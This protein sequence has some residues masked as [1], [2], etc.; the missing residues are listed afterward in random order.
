MSDAEKF[1]NQIKRNSAPKPWLIETVLGWLRFAQLKPVEAENHFRKAW[2]LDRNS[3]APATF[4]TDFLMKLEKFDDAH[5][6]RASRRF[7]KLD[8]E[9]ITMRGEAWLKFITQ[10]DQP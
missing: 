9:K 3:S 4:L 5:G 7:L 2:E 8:G 10:C 1:L 6:C